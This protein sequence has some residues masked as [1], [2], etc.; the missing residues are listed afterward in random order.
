M[1]SPLKPFRLALL[2]FAGLTSL[3]LLMLEGCTEPPREALRLG[4]VVVVGPDISK[5]FT[6]YDQLD[7]A[8]LRSLCQAALQ[9]GREVVV[10]LK[11]IGNPNDLPF[12]RCELKAVSAVDPRQTL[13]QKASMNAQR[14]EVMRWNAQV[15]ELFLQRSATLLDQDL[16]E[17]TDLNGFFS[18][19]AELFSEPQFDGREKILFLHTDGIHDINGDKALICTLP[20]DVDFYSSGWKN[21]AL[22]PGTGKFEDTQ[23]FFSFMAEKLKN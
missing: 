18:Q 7:T 1:K 12:L 3:V 16:Q 21:K 17:N 20:Q 13:S 2:N 6:G 23:G 22:C 14:Q 8:Q 10:A 19:A 11:P 5:T 15:I 4:L 9:S